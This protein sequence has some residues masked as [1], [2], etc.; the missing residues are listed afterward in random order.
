LIYANQEYKADLLFVVIALRPS[1]SCSQAENVSL[2]REGDNIQVL[3]GGK[4]FTTYYFDP[5]T[6][7]AYLQPLRSARGVVVTRGFPIGDTVPLAEQKDPSLEPHQR[8]LY[9][10]HGDI[11]GLDFWGEEVFR[12]FYGSATQGRCN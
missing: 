9:F 11:N 4:P 1:L 8:P 2:M 7:K 3:I 12:R 5:K 6:A 10:A